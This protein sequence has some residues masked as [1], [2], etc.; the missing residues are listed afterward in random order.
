MDLS[1]AW[2]TEVMRGQKKSKRGH[3]RQVLLGEFATDPSSSVEHFAD[4]VAL[5]VARQEMGILQQNSLIIE[6]EG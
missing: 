6:R 3:R 2:D 1:G 5:G 4:A